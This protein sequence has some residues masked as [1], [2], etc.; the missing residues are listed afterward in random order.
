MFNVRGGP[1][2]ERRAFTFFSAGSPDQ[3]P[4]AHQPRDAELVPRQDVAT[5]A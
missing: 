2:F 3:S 5:L 1:A 4:R